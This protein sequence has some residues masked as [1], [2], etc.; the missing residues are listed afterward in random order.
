M[1]SQNP[2]LQAGLAFQEAVAELADLAPSGAVQRGHGSTF[3]AFTNSRIPALNVVMS[4]DSR[5]D[6]D[7]IALLAVA[8]EKQAGELPWSIRLRG[9]PEEDIARFA[10]KHGLTTRSYQPFML[11]PLADGDLPSAEPD[12]RVRRLH[13]SEYQTFA[14]VLGSAFGAPAEVVTSL[15]TQDVLDRP[16]ITAYVAESNGVPA[17]AGL[18]MLAAGHV[19]LG[20]IGTVL[21]E[22][23][24][25]LAR[26]LVDAML[27]DGRTAGAHTAFLHSTDETVSFFEQA[28][29][30]TA[31]FWT[32]F[33]A[34]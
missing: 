15:Y 9:E 18:S 12:P 17:A 6:P 33:S 28:G 3:M 16:S 34:F 2:T 13:G 19:A 4:V 7:D 30:Q 25:G 8:L 27:R 21:E 31:E 26:A 1:S 10:A 22:R 32:S 23:G 29:F 20:N 24:R 14:D 5:P 11:R